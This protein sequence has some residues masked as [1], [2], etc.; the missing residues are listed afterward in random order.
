MRLRNPAPH[1]HLQPARAFNQ[2]EQRIRRNIQLLEKVVRK[3]FIGGVALLGEDL[4]G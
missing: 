3:R 2:V 1:G 4:I